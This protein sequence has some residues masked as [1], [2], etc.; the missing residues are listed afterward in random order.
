MPCG[1]V[2]VTI[3]PCPAPYA[4][5]SASQASGAKSSKSPNAL[6]SSAHMRAATMWSEV[7]HAKRT[8]PPS[9]RGR[10]VRCFTGG[11]MPAVGRS[12]DQRIWSR[13][14]AST[15]GSLSSARYDENG[16]ATVGQVDV[17]D[18]EG[19]LRGIT[20]VL[21]QWSHER[22]EEGVDPE[23]SERGSVRLTVRGGRAGR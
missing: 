23:A 2:H 11:R 16:G 20:E 8:A 4:A 21:A 12:F 7:T 14:K 15:I 17:L 19:S 13:S 6:P 10:T 18:F 1:E 3:Q 5:E 9:G 22:Q